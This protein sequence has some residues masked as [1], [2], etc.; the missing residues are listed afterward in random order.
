MSA[1]A[2]E[3][4]QLEAAAADLRLAVPDPTI[5][6]LLDYLDLLYQ[7]NP[8]AGLTSV[9]RADAVRLHL[10]DSLSAAEA[11]R[12]ASALVDLGT[13]GGLPG[14][15]L[16]LVH[17]ELEVRLV[18]SKRRKCSFLRDAVRRLDLPNCRVVECDARLLAAGEAFGVADTTIARAFMQPQEML[19]LSTSIAAARV[20]LMV[21]PSA[22]GS[23]SLTVPDGWSLESE[24]RIQ[25]PGGTERRRLLS[26]VRALA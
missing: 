4:R 25:L 18:E 16:A 24:R 9:D 23:D 22:A 7:W 13:G 3:R 15:P 5:R 26:Y 12:S 8:S 10:A 14:I 11:V 20:V 1:A 6:K 17:P 19:D 21:G 2:D